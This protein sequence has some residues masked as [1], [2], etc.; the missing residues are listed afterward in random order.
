MIPFGL[1]ER[2]EVLDKV[3]DLTAKKLFAPG[4]DQ[5][6]WHELIESRREQI[7][8]CRTVEEFESALRDLLA[9]LKISHV[10]FFHQSLQKIASNYAIGA[11]F[12]P[13]QIN[14]TAKWMFQDVHDG[15]PPARADIRPGDLLLE[16]DGHPVS[17]PE[18]PAFRMG[19]FC[20]I[21]VEKLNGERATV[22][23]GVPLPKSKYHPINRPRLVSWS[24]PA[25]GIGYLK[26]AGFPGQVGM[27]VARE[28]D[29]AILELR[30]CDRLIVDL[31]GNP[32]GGAGGLR[33]MGYLTPDKLPVG[34]SLSKKR[35]EKGYKKEKLPRF[36]KIPSRKIELFVLAFRYA[37]ADKS[38]VMVTEGLG[39]QPFHGR[40]VLLVN[41]HTA[42]AAETITGFARENKLAAIVG[43]RTAGQV[44]GGTGFKVG[45]G[46]VLRIP[47]MTFYTWNGNSL[48][49]VGVEP[50]HIVDLSRDALRSG[51][52]SQMKKAVE[53][54]AKL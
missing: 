19:G 45:H 38:I 13:C 33:L 23:L 39:P 34:Y 50:D 21:A 18:R 41:E 46:F 54:A 24:K 1:K 32:G 3:K 17:P 11:T 28:I 12:Q 31:R 36:G 49:G 51:H 42:S 37:F 10:V 8:K 16:V 14:G 25:P 44:L 5:K 35:A 26:A 48:E 15:S 30:D 7:L 27:D 9:E 47:V 2:T 53:V 43:T 52:D 6:K 4:F 40:I 20:Q 22:P 29:H